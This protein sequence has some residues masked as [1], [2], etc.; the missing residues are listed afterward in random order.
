M[1]TAGR[2]PLRQLVRL[3]LSH[4]AL[5]PN[6]LS[7]CSLKTMHAEIAREG[8]FKALHCGNEVNAKLTSCFFSKQQV[9]AASERQTNISRLT[10]GSENAACCDSGCGL[11]VPCRLMPFVEIVIHRLL[12]PSSSVFSQL[13]G[14][15]AGFLYARRQKL[16]SAFLALTSRGERI[17]NAASNRTQRSTFPGQGRAV[18]S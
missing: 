10:V 6:G 2:S 13:A 8:G 12:F 15:T 16:V 1:C 4:S 9:A 3:S 18:G 7:F 17:V 5:S 14:V 11:Q